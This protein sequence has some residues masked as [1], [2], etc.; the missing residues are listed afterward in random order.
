VSEPALIQQAFRFDLAPSAE[1]AE[2]LEACVGAS[3]FWFNQ[4]LAL[5]KERLEE[6][7]RLGPD[8]GVDVPWSYQAL[9]SAFRG[10]EVKDRLAPWRGEVVT[11]SYQAGLEALGRALQNFSAGRKAGRK[12]GFP[13]FRAR[14]R[15]HEAV[16][17][18]RPRL[19]GARHVDLDRRLGPVRTRE[20][21]RKLLRLLERDE[22]ARVMR[23]TVQR[24]GRGWCISFTVQ[25]S[26][27]QRAPRRPGATVGVDV[28]LTRL[29]TLS[30]GQTATNARPLAAALRELRRVQRQLDRQRRANNPANFGPDGRARKGCSI[31]VK[32]RRMLRTEDRL[33]RLHERVANLRREQAHQLTTHLTREYGVIGVET[34]AVRNLMANRRLAR[35]IADVGWGTVLTQLAYKTSWSGGLVVAADRYYPSSKTCSACGAVKAKLSLA[36][37]VFACDACEHEQD[38]DLNAARNLAAMAR[39]HAQAEGL[40]SFIARTGREMPNARGGRVS[41][42][43]GEPCPVKREDPHGSSQRRKALAVAL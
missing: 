6:R 33:R 20:S 16:I 24:S 40:P 32:S 25:R 29:A 4:G 10:E 38:R 36:E 34:L 42:A 12:V 23:A 8:A 17:F 35:H 21:M 1:Q 13:R 37:R 27:K 9:C 26:P 18:Q 43:T 19:P 7:D 28:G 15:C 41:L 31:W 14:G 5:V 22:Q 11:G 30:T 2:F 39:D 3:R